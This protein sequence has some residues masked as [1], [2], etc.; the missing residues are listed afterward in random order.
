MKHFLTAAC[1]LMTVVTYAQSTPQTTAGNNLWSISAGYGT[2]GVLL[3]LD[4][5]VYELPHAIPLKVYGDFSVKGKTFERSTFTFDN[6]DYPSDA[7]SLALGAGANVSFT[8][9]KL[10]LQ[11]YLGGRYYYV[12]FKD[13]DLV[14]AIGEDGIQRTSNGSPVGPSVDNAYGNTFSIDVGSWIGY[15]ITPMIEI[16]GLA[17][18]SPAEFSTAASLFGK[19]WA[20]APTTNQYYVKNNPLRFQGAIRFNF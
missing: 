9:D 1:I 12:R 2:Q 19:Y 16:G 3:R 20:Q 5:S 10:H 11:P 6:S 8:F 4:A 18:F 7:Y 13:R 15:R 17:G 14:A